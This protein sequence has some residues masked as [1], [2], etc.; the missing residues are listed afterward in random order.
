MR[1]LET[2]SEYLSSERSAS[3]RRRDFSYR[4]F[5]FVVRLLSS[6]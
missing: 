6:F 3:R 4:A 1:L 5:W 2:L